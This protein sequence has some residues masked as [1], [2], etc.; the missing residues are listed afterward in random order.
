APDNLKNMEE[1]GIGS[2]APV[3]KIPMQLAEGQ[4]AISLY[5]QF[6]GPIPFA[7]LALTQQ[8]ACNYGQSWPMLV[9]LPLCGYLD[10]LQQHELGVHPEDM[11][12]KVVT[13][14]EIAHQ[15]WGQTV[16]FR[17]YRD[18]WMSEGFAD[19]SASLYLLYTRKKPDDYRDFWK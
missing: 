14:H 19:M 15:W 17:S 7:K 1:A 16:G 4:N 8:Y 18:Q 11:Y 12:W 10:A 3:S 13:A 2:F 9:Y 6:Y 5:T